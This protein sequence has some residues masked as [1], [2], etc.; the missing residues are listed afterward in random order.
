MLG[1]CQHSILLEQTQNDGNIGVDF[2]YISAGSF[3]M[4]SSSTEIGHQGDEEYYDATLQ[5]DF[6][7]MTS[8]VSQSMFETLLGYSSLD[9]Q[10]ASY[11]WEIFFLHTSFLGIWQDFANHL[12]QFARDNYQFDIQD[13]YSCQSSGQLSVQCTVDINPYECTGY[14]LPTEAEWEYAA[15]SGSSSSIWT[16]NAIERNSVVSP[17][18][19][20]SILY[21]SPS[22]DILGDYAWYCGNNY[23]IIG[24]KEIMSLYPNMW[25]LYDMHGNVWEWVQDYYGIYLG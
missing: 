2:V 25:G 12:T 21:L 20:D 13:C 22:Q 24:T 3:T 4:G 10:L 5:Q 11:G 16:Q 7:M 19:C 14:R 9:G 18:S 17:Y 1:D 6:V 8:E 15:R 23:D